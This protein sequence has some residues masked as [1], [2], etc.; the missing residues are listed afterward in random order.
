MFLRLKLHVNELI[1]DA[2]Y[3]A[4]WTRLLVIKKLKAIPL[5]ALNP[6][7]CKG[8]TMEQKMMKCEELSRYQ[9][10]RYWQRE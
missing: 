3:D 8:D 4:N 9:S 6:R 2:A 1:A 5:I 10:F 7:N